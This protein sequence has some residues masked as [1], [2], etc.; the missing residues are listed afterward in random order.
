MLFSVI[1]YSL[2]PQVQAVPSHVLCSYSLF[3]SFCFVPEVI[4]CAHQHP[5]A[6]TG[7]SRVPS[8]YSG[9]KEEPQKRHWQLFVEVLSPHK[10]APVP[11]DLSWECK[12]CCYHLHAGTIIISWLRKDR[13][14]G[15]FYKICIKI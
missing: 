5:L 12:V 13:K 14:L 10:T 8:G 1:L 2:A 9:T 11:G 7:F 3:L 4:A 6:L 15:C